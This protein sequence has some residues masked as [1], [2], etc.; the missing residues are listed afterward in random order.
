MSQ[1]FGFNKRQRIYLP[2][3]R[4]CDI[5]FSLLLILLLSPLFL[6]LSICCL[7]DTKAFPIFRQR[8]IGKHNKTFLILKFRTMSKKTP[9][10]VPTHQLENPEVYITK[11]GRLLRK[12]SLDELPQLFNIFIGQMS[13][14]GPRPALWNQE[15]LI[16]GRNQKGVDS[17]RPGLTGHAQIHGRDAVS[18]EEKVELDAYYLH[19]FGLWMDIKIIFGSI[20]AVIKQKD[21]IE[22]EP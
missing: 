17:L 10:D 11:F 16:E 6:V 14:I 2:F 18:I 21:I 3:K 4:G 9:S 20:A 12:S 1:V 8:R 15:D 7:I 5:V 19:H 22:G 13:F